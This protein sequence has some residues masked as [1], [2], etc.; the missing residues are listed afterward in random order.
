MKEFFKIAKIYYTLV[1]L[2]LVIVPI[3]P[4]VFSY[5]VSHYRPAYFDHVS[6][7]T[8]FIIIFVNDSIPFWL[9]LVGVFLLIK[10]R[11]QEENKRLVKSAFYTNF[12]TIFIVILLASVLVSGQQLLFSQDSRNLE[13]RDPFL[14]KAFSQI[15]IGD[16]WDIINSKIQDP[17]F[18]AVGIIDTG[19]DAS[20]G[21]HP[22][23]QNVNLDALSPELLKDSKSGG[24][25]TQV[26][27]IIGANNISFPDVNNYTFP[28]LNGILSGVH[29]LNYNLKLGKKPLSGLTLFGLGS[30]V[31]GLLKRGVKI[32]NMSFANPIP[33]FSRFGNSTY[34]KIFS[35]KSEILFV[36]PAGQLTAFDFDFPAVDAEF[37]SPANL[38]DD[39]DNV[40][41]VGATDITPG[42]EDQ[43]V[44]S[45]NF[46]SAVNISAP[47]VAVYS[48]APRGK[49]DFPADVEQKDK[50]YTQEF[51]GTS[52]SAPMVTGV[53][54]LIKAIKPELRPEDIKRILQESADSIF[55]PIGSAEAG[56]LLGSGCMATSTPSGQ[57][58]R[59]CRLNAE[60]AVCHPLV[61]NCVP[62]PPPCILS[63]TIS[64]DTTIPS[65]RICVVQG[66]FSVSSG[67]TLT[68]EPGVVMKFE[69]ASS[70]LFV[71]GIL[72]A[73]GSTSSPIIF[74]SL[75]DDTVGGDTN[76]DGSTSSPQAGD[77]Q[78]IFVGPFGSATLSHARVRFGGHFQSL[79]PQASLLVQGILNLSNSRLTK[80]QGVN[81]MV[82]SDGTANITN[83]EIDNSTN[84]GLLNIG[85]AVTVH[86]SQFHDNPTDGINNTFAGGVLTV[87][88]S[89]FQR[90]SHPINLHPQVDF[91]HSGNTA[92]NNDFNGII[93]NGFISSNAARI[94]TKDF[95]PY[96]IFSTPATS[97]VGVAAGSSLT[98]DPGVVVKLA[99]ASS[100]MVVN[101][102]LN[103]NGILSQPVIF[104]SLKDDTVGGDTN[105]DG[106]TSS[107]QAGDWQQIFVGP[108]GS[109]T[110]SHARVR[111]GGHFQSLSP[112]AGL[113][114]QGILNLSN[115]R[116]TKNQ[117]VNL[118][119]ESDGTAN[120]TNSEIDNSTNIGILILPSLSQVGINQSS[121]HDNISFGVLS[122]GPAITTAINNWWGSVTG[123]LHP[124]L[125]PGGL[126]NQVSNF[127]DFIPFLT[128]DPVGILP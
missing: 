84:I 21:R 10:F 118:M 14:F 127:V 53:A 4:V 83:S 82:E 109:A 104:T 25:G 78:Q 37:I 117:G 24:H 13:Q 85:G 99:F 29:K 57:V 75:K 50:N 65:Q 31:D 32:I 40:V 16:A 77:W 67:R 102:T 38:G 68:I 49:G 110:L 45:T 81:L 48:P 122:S 100:A 17:V 106:S 11:K 86:D 12:I 96:I 36:I 112:Q 95:I 22:E 62:P 44:S 30:T 64:S 70:G 73:Q 69:S 23:F 108:F 28:Q 90:N 105:N 79:S 92:V 91:T 89:D 43:R 1:I 6:D 114:V 7:F 98:I 8:L 58:Q 94:W 120:I 87:T 18:V 66:T 103:V 54:G 39:F 101:G 60:K 15:K 9:M 113:L 55:A 125:N 124:T 61:L 71:D 42:L 76:N 119:V 93:M 41:T 19:V 88:N 26:T 116:L 47:G 5:S 46:G 56:K 111:F 126:G 33:G 34:R 35:K 121:I 2:S 80:N 107:P 123:P 128:S 115:S 97:T 63:G 3:F 27:G 52:A 74:T 51:G 59:G 20:N 72:N